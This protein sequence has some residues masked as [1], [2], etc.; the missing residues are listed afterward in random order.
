MHDKYA[1]ERLEMALHDYPVLR[2]LATG[3]AGPSVPR[4]SYGGA[5]ARAGRSFRARTA[6]ASA[7]DTQMR[8]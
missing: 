7:V 6:A 2:F 8:P 4:A 3:I 5:G 1:Y